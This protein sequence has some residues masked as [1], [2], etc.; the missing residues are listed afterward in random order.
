MANISIIW[1]GK[2]KTPAGVTFDYYLGSTS[3]YANYP[4]FVEKWAG[5]N[6]K[7]DI[8]ISGLP[9]SGVLTSFSQVRSDSDFSFSVLST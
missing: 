7:Y 3:G 9:I 1:D 2:S 4:N 5:T 8:S 6:L